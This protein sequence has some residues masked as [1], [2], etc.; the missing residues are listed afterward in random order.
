MRFL[1]AQARIEHG[2]PADSDGAA[3]HHTRRKQ[4]IEWRDGKSTLIEIVHD[5]T[6][7]VW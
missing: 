6:Y 2:D 4:L 5:G 3:S 7:A 1:M